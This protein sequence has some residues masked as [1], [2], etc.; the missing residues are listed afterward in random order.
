MK[1]SALFALTILSIEISI[2]QQNELLTLIKEDKP[3]KELV[4]AAFKSSRVINNHSMELIGKGVM[5]V[6]ILHRFGL[7]NSGI[8]NLFGLDQ[9]TM[10][11]GFDY[12]IINNLTAG[13]GRSTY[14]KDWDGFI[15]WRLLQ[16][17]KGLKAF[18]F[19]IV[20]VSGMMVNTVPINNADPKRTFS[21][22]SSYYHEVIFGKKI[23]EKFSLQLSPIFVHRNLV[24]RA[25]E[26]NDVYAL[27]VG[28]RIKLSR[29]IA[30]V[31]DYNYIIRGIDKNI[32]S[33][34][35]AIGFDIETGGHVFQLHFSNTEGMNERAFI[36]E[37]INE[38]SKG[39]FNFGFNLSR[40]FIISK[41][42]KE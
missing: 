5:D 40:V 16:Q 9:A 21:E 2:A 39:D 27:G 7:L 28:G 20:W 6:R 38:W 25:G 12:G 13:F 22:R 18:P 11:F 3:K 26:E 35:L 42:K 19:S 4:T 29:R 32:Y 34:P 31:A 14:R 1:R 24:E 36:T 23:S 41:R 15:K 37:T 17:A 8:K 30:F 33:H 10:R